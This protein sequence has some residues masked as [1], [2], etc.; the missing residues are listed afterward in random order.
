MRLSCRRVLLRAMSAIVAGLLSACQALTPVSPPAPTATTPPPFIAIVPEQVLPGGALTVIG[1]DWQPGESITIALLPALPGASALL[2]TTT[3]ADESGR[4][5]AEA[6]VPLAATPGTWQVYAQSTT[7]GRLASA[8]LVILTPTPT[9]PP[10]VTATSAPPPPPTQ[11][12]RPPRP[13]PTN[14][15]APTSTPP[16]PPPTP[17]PPPPNF[18]A[19]RGE[20]FNNPNL[21]GAP[22]LVRFDAP[23]DFNWGTGAP[24]FGLPADNFSVRWTTLFQAAPGTYRFSFFVD[25]GVRLFIDNVLVLDE[26]QDGPPRTVFRDVTLSGRVYVLRVEYYERTGT[27]LIRFSVGG[28]PTPTPRPTDTPRLPTPTST[29]RPPTPTFAPSPTPIP[30]PTATSTPTPLPTAPPLPTPTPSP[31]PI[32]LPTATFTPSPTP[33][34]LPTDTP[35]PTPTPTASPTP[36]PTATP[37][38]TPTPT[39]TP[40]PTPEPPTPSP[41]PEPPTPTPTPSPTPETPT[42]TAAPPTPTPS[43]TPPPPTPTPPPLTPTITATLTLSNLQLTVSS[44]GW[45]AR[46]RVVIALASAPDGSDAAVIARTRTDARG[47][48]TLSLVL[49]EAP[50]EEE[51]LYVVVRGQSSRRAVIAPVQ[52]VRNGSP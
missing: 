2:L 18:P 27:A 10:T 45:L 50:A 46:E 44:S 14:T 47:R 6:V 1:S 13:R 23:L 5:R 38:P 52:I 11:T 28:V 39:A 36:S 9:A 3:T 32:P 16:P 17:L 20:Y 40:T 37:T 41:T 31:T 19:W 35:T 22:V 24:D 42:P 7:P 12:P 30:L 15:P 33:I 48:F 26:W 49:D 25:D 51:T 43:P 34:P 21:A 8:S 29:P 4:F